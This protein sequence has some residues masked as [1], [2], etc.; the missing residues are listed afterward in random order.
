[1]VKQCARCYRQYNGQ[2]SSVCDSCW[3]DMGQM[4]LSFDDEYEPDIDSVFDR[5]AER[6]NRLP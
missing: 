4:E 3:V 5:M 1:M 6:E 2:D